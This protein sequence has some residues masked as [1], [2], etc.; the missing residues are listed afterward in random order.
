MSTPRTEHALHGVWHRGDHGSAIPALCR[1]LETELTELSDDVRPLLHRMQSIL[2]DYDEF[3]AFRERME[4]F[5][6]KYPQ[7]RL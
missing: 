5:V 4:E 1:Q 3:E 2:A 6:T 7:F